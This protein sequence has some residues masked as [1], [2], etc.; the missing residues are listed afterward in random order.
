MKNVMSIILGGGQGSR[1]YPLTKDRSKPAVPIG[2]KYRLIDIPITNCLR[3]GFN[4]IFVLTQ[5]NSESLN[6]HITQTYRF[7]S[8]HSGFVNVLAAEQSMENRDWFQG[9]ADAVRKNLKHILAFHDV[10]Y[11]LILSGDQIYR[12]DYKKLLDFHIKNKMELTIAVKPVTEEETSALGIMKVDNKIIT[13][14]IEKPKEKEILKNFNSKEAAQKSFKGIESNREYL[15]S[16]GIYLFNVDVLIDIL[17]NDN[18]DFGKEIIPMAIKTKKV[19]SFFFNDYWEDV[20]T[21]KSFM[22]AHLDFIS[23]LPQFN[24]YANQIFTHARHLP[25][26]KVVDCCIN[27]AILSEGSIIQAASIKNSIVGIRSIIRDN[28]TIENSIIMGADYYESNMIKKE[29]K[30]CKKIN[31]GINEN[32]IINNA[33]IDKNARIGKNCKIINVNNIDNFESEKYCIKEGVVIITKNSEIEDNT[34]I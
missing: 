28:V 24:L 10:K 2:G 4:R 25:P 5:F 18:K 13:D 17:K 21:I 7:D 23:P 31:I 32:T 26:S 14:F 29:N 12:M 9:T 27:N 6:K 11:V 19:G 16:M 20:G 15:A 3:S 22:K 8:F 34:V 1:L 30:A 33:I